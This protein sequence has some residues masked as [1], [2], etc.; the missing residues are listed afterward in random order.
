[1]STAEPAPSRS[2]N[3]QGGTVAAMTGLSRISGFVRDMVISYAFGASAMADA[4]FVAFRIPNFFRRLFAEGA[5][6]QAFVPVLSAYRAGGDR[7][8][9]LR[10]VSV[11]SAHFS[12]VLFIVCLAGVIG[13]PLLVALFAPGFWQDPAKLALT[14]EM[15]RITFPYLGFI[16]LTAFA[17]ALLNAHHRFAV[18]AFTPV[19]LNLSLIAAALLP[20]TMFDQPVLALAWG[21]FVA[22]VAQFLFQL[23]ALRRLGVLVA[24]RFD[25][26]HAG[27][28]RVGRLVL[29]SVVA[30]SASQINSL[31]DTMIASLLVTGSISWLYYADRLLELPIGVV[32]VAIATVMLPNLSRLNAEQSTEAFSRTL[33]W[34]IRMSLLL[35]LPAA[36]ALY[37]L[38]VPII[39]TIFGRGALTPTDVAMTALALEAFAVGLVGL[40]LVK[41]TVPAYFAREDTRTPL[42]FALVAVGVNLALNLAL[43]KPMGHVGLALATSA[44]SL[45]QTFLLVR[46]IVR[47]GLYRPGRDFYFFLLRVAAGVAVLSAFIVVLAPPSGLWTSM[48]EIERAGWLAALCAGGGLAYFATLWAAG[49]RPGMLRYHA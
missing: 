20:A 16:S 42:R 10:F 1:M 39:A 8:A 27:V 48:G 38:A 7:A 37:L 24:P 32:A 28:H 43:F 21:V 47:A 34:G 3:R 40:T 36:A 22:G 46:G 18:P 12:L 25:R 15:V 26:Q 33:D 41:I 17:G 9:F 4:F 30:S 5:F 49:L 14:S 19:L 31:V 44:A 6:S 23:P 2:L 35:V 29:P 11:M 13:A 45:V